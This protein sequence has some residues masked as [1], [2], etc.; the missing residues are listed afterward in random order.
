MT[1]STIIGLAC[2]YHQHELTSRLISSAR[3]LINP[4]QTFC[5]KINREEQPRTN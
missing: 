5:G 1:V 4:F 2:Q 3:L